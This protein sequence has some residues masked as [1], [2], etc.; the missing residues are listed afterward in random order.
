[1]NSRELSSA[2]L[3]R[4]DGDDLS[5]E[6]TRLLH[7]HLER[8]PASRE[9]ILSDEEMHLRL[10]SLA[11][12]QDPDDRFVDTVLERL[13]AEHAP[14]KK[15][16]SFRRA[17][18][19]RRRARDNRNRH[20][21]RSIAL[22]AAAMLLLGVGLGFWLREQ[23]ISGIA[24]V[25][26]AE[27]AVWSRETPGARLTDGEFLELSDGSAELR[28]DHG[29]SITL[30]G[31]ARLQ[32][33]STGVRVRYGSIGARLPGNRDR[34]RIETP[35]SVIHDRDVELSLTVNPDG[36][37]AIDVISGVLR[38]GSTGES[39][40]GVALSSGGLRRGQV[41][42]Q[43]TASG[44]RPVIT[45]AS[46]EN[47]EFLGRI[48]L[49]GESVESRRLPAFRK[50]FDEITSRTSQEVLLSDWSD[51]SDH[52][53]TDVR[54][55]VSVSVGDSTLDV[56]DFDGMLQLSERLDEMLET[57]ASNEVFSASIDVDG[58]HR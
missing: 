52:F 3:R 6:E 34:F 5:A 36:S 7:R 24:S 4:L 41:Y 21:Q 58:V 8:K 37:S 29:A 55:A 33:H 16:R 48:T 35:L 25:A 10:K 27:N 32:V 39:D 2:W 23:E 44:L 53:G 47:G 50:L 57:T 51:F 17:T 43:E 11:R 42:A 54:R 40:R 22:V 18:D 38:I 20:K 28:F 12:S 46:G 9:R 14:P 13:R 30:E 45:K 56:F 49:A 1:M 15:S 31:P 26:H 19:S